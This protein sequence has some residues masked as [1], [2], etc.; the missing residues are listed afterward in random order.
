MSIFS[1]FTDIVN[2]N[3]NHLLDKAEHPQ[4]MLEL[5]INEME[6]TLVEVRRCAAN[7]LF[8]QKTLQKKEQS[9]SLAITSWAKK[10]ETA[11]LKER[12]D[13]AKQALMEKQKLVS[14]M[15]LVSNELVQITETINKVQADSHK[16][17]AKLQEAK[18]KRQNFTLKAQSI[19]AQLKVRQQSSVVKIDE[20]LAK[21]DRYEEKINK[22]EAE[23]DAYDLMEKTSLCD[24]IDQLQAQDELENELAQLRK[25]VANA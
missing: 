14:D 22:L 12:E 4:K 3:I 24:E 17:Q 25:K 23:V 20:A 5:V 15:E 9:L 7:L 6:E 11:L 13:L 1:R 19:E 21:F 8:E 2:A 16:L 10:A 18:I